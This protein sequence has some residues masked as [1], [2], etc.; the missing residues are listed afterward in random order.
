MIKDIKLLICTDDG[1]EI[2]VELEPQRVKAVISLLGLEVENG[3]VTMTHR[4]WN[5]KRENKNLILDKQ[6]SLFRDKP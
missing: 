1:N 2:A 4:K 6:L 5:R 3:E